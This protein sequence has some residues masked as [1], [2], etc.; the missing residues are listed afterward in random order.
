M[1]KQRDCLFRPWGIP[2]QGGVSLTYDY[3]RSLYIY[4][5]TVGNEHDGTFLKTRRRV[6]FR[7][8]TSLP[9]YGVRTNMASLA[10]AYFLWFFFGIFGVHH[11][12]LKR[13]R[14]AFVW[15]STLGG[16]FGLGWIRDFWRLPSYVRQANGKQEDGHV[17]NDND[18]KRG[19]RIKSKPKLSLV[20]WAG[21]LIMGCLFSHLVMLAFP[22]HWFGTGRDVWW[23]RQKLSSAFLLVVPPYAAAVGTCSLT[24]DKYHQ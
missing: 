2:G 5:H 18:L 3:T 1:A 11:F 13:D 6:Y 19:A 16:V 14:Q 8:T 4:I 22:Q 24:R 17:V 23:V 9:S 10:L 15:W 20:R 21:M 12:Y 7:F